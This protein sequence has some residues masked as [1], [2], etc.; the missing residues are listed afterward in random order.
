MLKEY[1][2]KI[3]VVGNYFYP[4][5]I[6]GVELVSSKLV[7]Y[8]LQFGNQIRWLAADVPPK[9]R[10]VR[11]GDIP[12]RCW[13]ITE[14]RLGFPYPIPFPATLTKLYRQVK[15]CDIVHLQD[16]LYPINI[17]TFVLALIL[18]KPVLITQY[19]KIIYYKQLYKRL[20]QK[21]AYWTIGQFMF[22][23]SDKVVFIT[24]NVRENMQH[25]TPHL[26]H[27]VVPL[28]VDTDFYSPIETSLRSK[29]RTEICGNPDTPIILF[30]GRMVERKG[31]HLFQPLIKKHPDWHW[32]L[33]GRP[34]DHN[35]SEWQEANITYFEYVEEA[36]LHELYALSDILLHPSIGEGVTLIVLECMACGTPAIVAKESLSEFDKNDQSMFFPVD[37][38]P[39]DIEKTLIKIVTNHQELDKFREKIRDYTIKRLSWKNVSEHYLLILYDLVEKRI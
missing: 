19:A 30:V 5:H 11:D 16:S 37:P 12:L 31:V 34:D 9:F 4:E 6:G 27:D 33:V 38:T 14:E 23:K 39:S 3:L 28:G 21:F 15:W 29:L 1:Q 22:I 35:P 36:K 26:M 20:L 10:V 8:Y 7:K 2:L 18:N 32:I 17:L 25:I 24:K 13:N